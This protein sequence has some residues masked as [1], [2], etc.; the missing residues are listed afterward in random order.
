MATAWQGE[1]RPK[2]IFELRIC[3]YAQVMVLA[4]ITRS[5]YGI[6]TELW[7]VGTAR[8]Y[9]GADSRE[10]CALVHRR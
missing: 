8:N 5:H 6:Y 4:R 3:V 7:G 1:P 2:C 9:T 10:R